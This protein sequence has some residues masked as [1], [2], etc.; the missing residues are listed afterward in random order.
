M[1]SDDWIWY[2]PFGI[3]MVFW[4]KVALLLAAI[5]I[6]PSRYPRIANFSSYSVR[7][8]VAVGIEFATMNPSSANWLLKV[9]CSVGSMLQHW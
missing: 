4:K 9:F 1:R 6:V 5:S 8:L 7:S 3:V 2:V